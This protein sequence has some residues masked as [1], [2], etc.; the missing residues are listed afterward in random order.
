MNQPAQRPDLRL[1]MPQTARFVARMRSEWG[2]AHVNDCLRRADKGEPGYFYAIEQG[3]IVGT[4]FPSG[5]AIEEWQ[6]KAVLWGVKFAVFMATPK[7]IHG[8]H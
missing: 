4:A 6:A 5:H 3:Q 7:G 2:A 8:A 1:S